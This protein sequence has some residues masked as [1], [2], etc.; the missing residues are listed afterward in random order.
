MELEREGMREPYFNRES[1]YP[2]PVSRVGWGA[3][4]AGF[5]IA[6]V[7]QILLNS[8]GVAIGL[9]AL[10]ANTD[11]S[12]TTLGVGAGIWT[13]IASM[14]SVFIGAW[15]AGRYVSILERGEG[16]LQGVLVWAL[17]LIFVLWIGT[18]GIA[19]LLSGATSVVGQGV[20]GATQGAAS[21]MGQS[22]TPDQ[23]GRGGGSQQGMGQQGTSQQGT[24][25]QLGLSG[26]HTEQMKQQ[27]QQA[28]QKGAKYGAA[29][30]W[31][32][33]GTAFLSLGA[34]IW[35][36]QVGFSRRGNDPKS[37]RA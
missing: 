16:P 8:L 25:D 37:P 30:A 28:A 6:T 1:S 19:S 7:V 35:G 10:G 36:G 12:G 13:I 33:F 11:T 9:S 26:T 2:Y 5:F 20:Q 31:W 4:L 18:T 14:V 17:S 29:A 24:S 23:M 27:A 15:V 32:F 22:G 34:A 21:Q 3:V